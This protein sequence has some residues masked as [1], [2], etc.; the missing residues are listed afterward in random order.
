M[1]KIYKYPET[2][3]VFVGLSKLVMAGDY[4]AGSGD[5]GNGDDPSQGGILTNENQIFE[6]DSPTGKSSLWD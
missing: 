2:E 1:K 4:G 3:I 6:D 5:I